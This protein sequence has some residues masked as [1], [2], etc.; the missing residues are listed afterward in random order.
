MDN[1]LQVRNGLSVILSDTVDIPKTIYSVGSA[2]S[3]VSN[4]LNDTGANFANVMP[5]FIVYNTTD[6]TCTLVVAKLSDTSLLLADDII[7]NGE[8]YTLYSVGINN[9][10]LLYVG[11]GG[12]LTVMTLGGDVV[13]LRNYN[14][15]Q[16]VPIHVTRV[17][18][19]GT[20]ASDI[21]ALW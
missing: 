4:Q 1:R 16:F 12:D 11:T 6:S 18:S 14:D 17:F 8:N 5:G 20:T 10:S 21:V 7:A 2:T 3:T 19:T 9:G 15:G 13:T